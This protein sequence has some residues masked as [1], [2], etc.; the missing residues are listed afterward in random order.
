MRKLDVV[1]AVAEKTGLSKGDVMVAVEAFLQEIK[2]S[3]KKGEPVFFRGFG[4]FQTVLRQAKPARDVRASKAMVIP[5]HYAPFFKP[6]AELKD[7]L[8]KIKID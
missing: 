6:S 4:N 1:N 2:D 8:K 5:A 7:A 3:L